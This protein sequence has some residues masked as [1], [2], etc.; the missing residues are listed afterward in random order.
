MVS[1]MGK[2]ID[3]DLVQGEDGVYAEKPRHRPSPHTQQN[4]RKQSDDIGSFF[5]GIDKGLD[6]MESL[7][8]RVERFLG[9]RKKKR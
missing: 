3:I 9:I 4:K 7:D 6:F 5:E 8:E 1:Q 2:P